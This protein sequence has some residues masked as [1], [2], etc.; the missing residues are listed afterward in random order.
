MDGL[1]IGTYHIVN[2]GQ[3]DCHDYLSTP[4]ILVGP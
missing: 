1:V 3:F 4:I 2:L